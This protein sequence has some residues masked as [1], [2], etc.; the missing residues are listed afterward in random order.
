MKKYAITIILLLAGCDSPPPMRFKV[1]IV[2]PD[3]VVHR[4]FE[5]EA[6]MPPVVEFYRTSG[7]R[8]MSGL[9]QLAIAPQGWMIDVRHVGDE[10]LR[11]KP[12]VLEQGEPR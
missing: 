10:P 9:R 7:M 8:A 11:P 3:G 6:V 12:L 5:H 4:E 2:R 1:A